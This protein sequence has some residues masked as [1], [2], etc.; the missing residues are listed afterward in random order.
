LAISECLYQRA[1]V[2]AIKLNKGDQ[3]TCK[4][5]MTEEEKSP[6][7]GTKPRSVLKLKVKRKKG[8]DAAAKASLLSN[9]IFISAK[10]RR[11]SP[12]PTVTWV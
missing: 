1:K 10:P 2:K 5:G 4:K 12:A 9:S 8:R 3:S 7:Q 11:K 6:N